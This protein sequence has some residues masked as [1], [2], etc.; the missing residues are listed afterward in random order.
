[1]TRFTGLLCFAA[2]TLSFC[3]KIEMICGQVLLVLWCCFAVAF[4]DVLVEDGSVL[5]IQ[6]PTMRANVTNS[7]YAW[8]GPI[9]QRREEEV[10]R[11]MIG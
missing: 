4:G 2:S 11:P 9:V 10:T 6:S 5:A 1:L 3:K 8:Y 7:L